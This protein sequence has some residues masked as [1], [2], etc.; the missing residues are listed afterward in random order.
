MTND[1]IDLRIEVEGE[2]LVAHKVV[3]INFSADMKAQE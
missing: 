3:D 1:E 2:A